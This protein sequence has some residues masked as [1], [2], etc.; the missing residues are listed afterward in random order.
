MDLMRP[1]TYEYASYLRDESRRVGKADSISFPRTEEEVKDILVACYSDDIPVTVQGARTGLAGAA[2]P[3]GGHILNLTRMNRVLG[4]RYDGEHFLLRV[5]PGLALSELRKM[6]SRRKFDCSGWSSQSMDA[7]ALLARAP[8]QFFPPDPTETTATVGGMVACN[9]SGARSYLYGATRGYIHSVVMLLAD[10]RRLTLTRGIEKAAG[11][12]LAL[13][14]EEGAP[15]E[16][17][18]PTYVMPKTKNTSGYYAQQD[19]DAID[20]VIGSDGTLGV[21]TEIELMLCPLPP[22][23]YGVMCLFSSSIKSVGFVQRLRPR[24]QD[25]ASMEYFDNRALDVLR[26]QRKSHAAF[27]ALPELALWIQAAV[28]VELHCEDEKTALERLKI[29]DEVLDQSECDGVDGWPM[30]SET[31]LSQSETWVARNQSD[32]DKMMFFR[33]AVPESVNLLIDKRKQKDPEITKLGSDM[34]VPDEHLRDIVEYYEQSVAN[35]GLQS[36]TWGHIGNNHLH[37]NILPNSMDEYRL[38]K[39]LFLEFANKVT[40]LS[41]SV[42]SEHGVGKLKADFLPVMYTEEHME[43]MKRLK[44]RFDQKGLLGSGNLFDPMRGGLL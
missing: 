35:Y 20:L 2:S 23:I 44:Y 36:A 26:E 7:L 22:C 42:S 4:C 3:N 37:V 33:H 43:Q 14:P 5:Q 1:L 24:G 10:G 11:R 9:A 19:M 27:S 41:G 13:F 39:K 16:I 15:I 40:E 12:A 17:D 38:G 28:Y 21:I 29:I 25:I 6:I 30:H 8:E 31:W 34:A 18:L 32:L